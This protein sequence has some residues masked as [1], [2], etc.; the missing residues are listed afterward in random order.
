MISGY[1]Q[2]AMIAGM[3]GKNGLEA[4]YFVHSLPSNSC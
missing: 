1:M 4:W 3:D 2:S